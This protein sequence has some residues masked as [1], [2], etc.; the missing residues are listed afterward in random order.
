MNKPKVFISHWMPEP[1]V[2]ILQKYCNVDYNNQT[3]ALSKQEF[4]EHAKGADALVI[5][6]ADIIDEE[7][8][9]ECPGLKVISSFGKGYDNIDIDACNKNNISVTINLDSLTDSTADMAITLLLSLCRKVIPA[10]NHVRSRDFK[11]WHTSNFLGK[12]L[13]HSKVGIIGLGRIGKAIARR[14]QAFNTEISYF[15]KVRSVDFETEIDAVYVANLEQ[16]LTEN[17]FIILSC[18]YTPQNYHLIDE[19]KINM[20]RKGT[21][22]VNICRGSIVDEKAVS[23]ALEE[24]HLWGYGSDVFEFEDRLITQHPKYIP[25][26]L[27]SQ[28]DRT[29]LTPHIGTGTVEAR[30]RLSISTA[31]QLIDVLNGKIPKGLV[32]SL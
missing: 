1:G 15:D 18:N 29:V 23:K 3:E 12:D 13:H 22:L 6:V 5:F 30:Q 31:R 21:V 8:I 14:V 26:S 2:T 10:D 7:I 4:I 17:E 25:E 16:L 20:M 27:L 28:T 19:E 9:E 24:E 11:G 32:K